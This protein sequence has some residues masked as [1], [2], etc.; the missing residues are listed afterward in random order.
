MKR[1]WVQISFYTAIS[2]AALLCAF[3]VFVV[4]E[5]SWWFVSSPILIFAGAVLAVL[6]VAYIV[7]LLYAIFNPLKN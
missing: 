4:P 6:V 1:D 2:M 7:F 5:W 3:K